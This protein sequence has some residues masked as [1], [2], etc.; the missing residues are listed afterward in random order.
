MGEAATASDS[1]VELN[2]DEPARPGLVS[3]IIPVGADPEGLRITLRSIEENF[4]AGAFEVLVA[5]DGADSATSA[6][7]REFPFVR[8]LP[9]SPNRGPA[10]ARNLAAQR[11]RGEVLAFLDADLSVWP[12]WW[13]AMQ[14]ALTQSD[15]AC[16]DVQVDPDQIDTFAHYFDSLVAFDVPRYVARH[17]AVSGN[18][19]IRRSALE[20]VG[21][22]DTRFRSGEDNEFGKRAHING[23]DIRYAPQ[24]GVY[25]PPR[26][27]RAQYRKIYRVV[28]GRLQLASSLPDRFSGYRLTP[29]LVLSLLI[30]PRHFLRSS[31]SWSDIPAS[32]RARVYLARYARNLYTLGA[33][34]WVTVRGP[35]G[36]RHDMVVAPA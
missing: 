15:L 35:E 20:R 6:A 24:M 18:L 34:V 8:E 33:L 10:A 32:R 29:R 17:H 9:L 14:E 16:G 19:A 1:S 3:I 12:Q 11:S 31:V 2:F 25:H 28:V 30:P 26:D 4:P 22:F 21:G 27:T 36:R 13:Q 5:N 23:I 7:C